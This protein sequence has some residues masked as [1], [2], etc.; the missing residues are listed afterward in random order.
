VVFGLVCGFGRVTGIE[1]AGESPG[2]NPNSVY[3]DKR[4]GKNQWTRGLALNNSIG[5]GEILTTPLQLAQFYCGLGNNGVVYTPHL[6]KEIVRADGKRDTTTPHHSFDL[7]FSPETR[8]LL[9]ESLRL[10][11]EGE[12]GTARSLRNDLYSIGGKTG[13]A[14]NPHGLEHALFVGLAPLEAPEI[15]V[16]AIVENAGHGS[17]VAAP[18]VGK[19]IRAYMSKKLS[20]DEPADLVV[21]GAE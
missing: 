11:V 3:Y 19:V 20:S 8:A 17:E 18:V 15:V 12:H 10:V 7:P 14:Q 16:C 6:V 5:Q 13:T 21:E 4:Y 1:I 9:M 2:L